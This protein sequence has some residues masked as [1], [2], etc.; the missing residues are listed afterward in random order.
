MEE[1]K[2]QQDTDRHRHHDALHLRQ[3]PL[4]QVHHRGC[5][6]A[7]QQPLPDC[8]HRGADHPPPSGTGQEGK[9]GGGNVAVGHPQLLEHHH[10]PDETPPSLSGRGAG[11]DARPGR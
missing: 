3:Q 2:Q 7:E 8:H 6:G 1:T 9:G 11:P 5:E 4:R 10:R